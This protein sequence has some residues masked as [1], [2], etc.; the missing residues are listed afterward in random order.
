[1][2]VEHRS[3]CC[4]KTVPTEVSSRLF[5]GLREIRHPE[6]G[7]PAGLKRTDTVSPIN[8]DLTRCSEGLKEHLPHLFIR[9]IV[10]FCLLFFLSLI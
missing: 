9:D 1:M 4:L 8:P 3:S 6:R 10:H 7:L 2:N 5:D